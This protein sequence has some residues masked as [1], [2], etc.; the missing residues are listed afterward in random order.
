[1]CLGRPVEELPRILTILGPAHHLVS[2]M[3]LDDLFHVEPPEPAVNMRDALL[4]SLSFYRQLRKIFF[5]LSL[6][7]PPFMDFRVAQ[8]ERR[9]SPFPQQMAGD[10]MHHVALGQEAATIL[11]GRSEHPLAAIAGGSSRY[12]KDES[13]ARLQEIA[14]PCMAFSRSL[15]DQFRGVLFEKA[16]EIGF[17]QEIS[18]EPM[19]FITGGQNGQPG[20]RNQIHLFKPDGQLAESFGPDQVQDKIDLH[21][22]PW[23]HASF[24]FLKSQGWHGLQ[25]ADRKGLYFVGPLA[26]LNAGHSV[27][28]PLAETFRRQLEQ[29]FGGFPNFS[30]AAAVGGIVLDILSAAEKMNDLFVPDKFLGPSFRTVPKEMGKEG[31]AALESPDGLIFHE[32]RVN[33]DGLVSDVTVLDTVE[34]NNAIRCLLTQKAVETLKTEDISREEIQNRIAVSLLA[35]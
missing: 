35:F 17:F 7:E 2:A 3:A 11:G 14:A 13:L 28:S 24:A 22:E 10:I 27:S 26:R 33:A 15:A 23:T 30:V 9:T 4:Y 20:N 21:S 8:R 16:R 19:A 31:R 1:M 34:A 18:S 12:I 29:D 5:L 25:S 6:W 32:Y